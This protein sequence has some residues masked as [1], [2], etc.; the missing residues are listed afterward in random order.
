MTT[1]FRCMR[2]LDKG[3]NGSTKKRTKS[4]CSSILCSIYLRHLSHSLFFFSF[5]L[6]FHFT[7]N[8]SVSRLSRRSNTHIHT[9][10]FKILNQAN[11]HHNNNTT[12]H[13]INSLFV[14]LLN[15]SLFF[16]S[17]FSPFFASI[18]SVQFAIMLA[19]HFDV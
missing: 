15:H 18:L 17:L 13:N 7:Y 16:S 14:S 3:V 9:K 12:I 19:F 1:T 6:P 11:Y 4:H 8:E 2:A 10:R 5:F